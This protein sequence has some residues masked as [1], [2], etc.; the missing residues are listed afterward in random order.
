MLQL[1][2][3][4]QYRFE[5]HHTF[6]IANSHNI[7]HFI[8]LL[9][10]YIIMNHKFDSYSDKLID[11]VKTQYGQTLFLINIQ[12]KNPEVPAAGY[13]YSFRFVDLTTVAESRLAE[14]INRVKHY[15]NDLEVKHIE[16]GS[17][18]LTG[19]FRQIADYI[20]RVFQSMR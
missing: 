11:R 15:F 19:D 9:D 5:E 3:V 13:I 4:P 6:Q 2:G 17:V 20:D 14:E 12:I 10:V 18:E 8:I 16:D 1:R 7:E